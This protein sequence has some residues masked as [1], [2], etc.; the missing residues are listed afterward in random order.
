MPL[1]PLCQAPRRGR[2]NASQRHAGVC[3]VPYDVQTMDGMFPRS[4][5]FKSLGHDPVLGFVFGV[6]DILRGTVTGFSYDLLTRSHRFACPE[7]RSNIDP[8]P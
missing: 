1:E 5:R 3:V 2:A 7:V 6:L 4:H 8:I